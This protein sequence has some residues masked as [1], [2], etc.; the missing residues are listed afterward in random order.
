M[1]GTELSNISKSRG[2]MSLFLCASAIALSLAVVVL[3]LAFILDFMQLTLK[4]LVDMM[5]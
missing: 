1:M 2:M 3:S 4:P 5:P